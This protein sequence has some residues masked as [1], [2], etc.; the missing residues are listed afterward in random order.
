MGHRRSGVS[1]LDQ[2]TAVPIPLLYEAVLAPPHTAACFNDGRLTAKVG[3]DPFPPTPGLHPVKPSSAL[4]RGCP[5]RS[6][7]MLHLVPRTV[8]SLPLT[9]L[10]ARIHSKSR[11]TS[12]RQNV[13]AGIFQWYCT[14]FS[15]E[16]RIEDYSCER[17]HLPPPHTSL[18]EHSTHFCRCR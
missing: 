1:V 10:R 15:T 4:T 11:A 14:A 7:E 2:S 8:A 12:S 3:I 9:R 17:N 5:R 16:L 18:L 6:G 13:V